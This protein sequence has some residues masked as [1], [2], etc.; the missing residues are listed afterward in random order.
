[1]NEWIEWAADDKCFSVTFHILVTL[2][3]ISTLKV[4]FIQSNWVKTVSSEKFIHCLAYKLRL[5]TKRPKTFLRYDFCLCD[6]RVRS[7]IINTL[8]VDV[9]TDVLPHYHF[10]VV[11]H[12]HLIAIIFRSFN[13]PCLCALLFPICYTWPIAFQCAFNLP[14]SSHGSPV[15]SA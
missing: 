12:L 11:S 3:P 14:H 1:M 13:A 7:I 6:L 4:G 9:N 2:F 10:F 8:A 15:F 5:W